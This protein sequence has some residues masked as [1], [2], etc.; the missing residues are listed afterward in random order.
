MIAINATWF[1][2][3][4]SSHSSSWMTPQNPC[5]IWLTRV[6]RWKHEQ[7]CGGLVSW[8]FQVLEWIHV[9]GSAKCYLDTDRCRIAHALSLFCAEWSLSWSQTRYLLKGQHS[10]QTGSGYETISWREPVNSQ[11][12]ERTCGPV[13]ELGRFPAIP[14]WSPLDRH[15][16]HIHCPILQ[17]TENTTLHWSKAAF[18]SSSERFYCRLHPCFG[19]L[20]WWWANGFAFL[21]LNGLLREGH[22]LSSAEFL[23]GNCSP[24]ICLNL[25]CPVWFVHA[26]NTHGRKA[27][28]DQ[29]TMG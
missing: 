8:A 23:H 3:S 2:D 17:M 27:T 16:G 12:S 28:R 25:Y 20:H 22:V 18:W 10:C 14:I 6:V 24:S 1:P 15:L 5:S 19:I 21:N 13:A 4:P 26:T 11:C 29:R 9:Y 7:I